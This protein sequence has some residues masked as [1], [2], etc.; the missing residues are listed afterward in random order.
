MSE[1]QTKPKLP[2][3]QRNSSRRELSRVDEAYNQLLSLAHRLGPHAKLPTFR[4]LCEEMSVSQATLDTAL[5][6]LE[7][8][9]ILVRRQRSGVYVSSR[10]RQRSIAVFCDSKYFLTSGN[11]P[12]WGILIEQIRLLALQNEAI[13]SLHFLLSGQEKELEYPTDD[14]LIPT[15]LRDDI[16]SGKVNGVICIGVPHSVARWIEAQST[17]VVAYAGAAQYVVANSEATLIQIGVAELVRQGCRRIEPWLKGIGTE[18]MEDNNSSS[19]LYEIYRGAMLAH[20]L[21]P[22]P[23]PRLTAIPENL[24]LTSV[25]YAYRLARIRLE[26]EDR[27]DAILSSDDMLTQGFLMGMF[28]TGLQ[29]NRDVR[30]ATHTNAG[31]TT[32]LAW[33][34][35][36][37]QLEFDPAEVVRVLFETLDALMNKEHPSW[38][39][40]ALKMPEF[41]YALL[42]RLQLPGATD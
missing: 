7:E 15:G 17:P 2:V 34:E 9:N 11:S 30:V 5:S 28:R 18:M 35:D 33:Q 31:S 27:P 25:E 10:L 22:L 36:L 23:T 26:A 1:R 13:L 19:S 42:P 41:H 16:A 6:R 40:T 8:Q 39:A 24:G 20:G 32:L 3:R 29:L 38:E 4:V 14:S 12:F 21:S 37:T